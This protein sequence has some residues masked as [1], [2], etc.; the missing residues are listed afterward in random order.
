LLLAHRKRTLTA[1]KIIELAIQNIPHNYPTHPFSYAAYYRDYQKEENEYLNLNEGIVGI[2]D[3]GFDTNDFRSTK[4]KL[5][6]YRRNSDFRRDSMTAIAYDNNSLHGNKF[7]PTATVFPYGGNELSMLMAHDAIR[8]N[9][10]D[11]YSFVNV[12]DTD[13]LKIIHSNYLKRCT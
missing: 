12:F 10:V 5:Y 2:F 8:N 1:Y 4:I 13:F 9:K 3:E 7:I 11:S 6:Q